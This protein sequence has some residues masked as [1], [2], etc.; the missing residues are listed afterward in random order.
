MTQICTV[1]L[2]MCLRKI[3]WATVSGYAEWSWMNMCG[4]GLGESLLSS[5]REAVVLYKTR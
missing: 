3:K 1:S 4:A 5:L 2:D